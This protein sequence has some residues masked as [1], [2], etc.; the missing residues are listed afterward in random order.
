MRSPFQLRCVSFSREST[1]TTARLSLSGRMTIATSSSFVNFIEV[2]LLPPLSTKARNALDRRRES[3]IGRAPSLRTGQA[4]LPHPA[5]Q[6]V[7]LPPRGLT[8]QGMS[9]SSGEETL[10]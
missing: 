2:L 10:L 7:V 4:V 5:L 6:S 9:L 1:V 3:G 8:G